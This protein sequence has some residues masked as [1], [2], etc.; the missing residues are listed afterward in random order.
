MNTLPIEIEDEIWTYYYKD[1]YKNIVVEINDITNKINDLNDNINYIK[2]IVRLFRFNIYKNN[3]DNYEMSQNLNEVNI[4]LINIH[5]Y[6]ASR[7]II[8]YNNKFLLNNKLILDFPV[9][10]RYVCT[11]LI[12]KSN[13]QK[14][15]IK[16]IKNMIDNFTSYSV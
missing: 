3:Y 11:S 4:N 8:F 16:Y 12:R 6:K 9:E 10:Y 5:E 15:M 2:S 14:K 1:L 13:F 7:L